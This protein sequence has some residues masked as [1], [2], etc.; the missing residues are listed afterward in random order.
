MEGAARFTQAYNITNCQRCCFRFCCC[1]KD[2]EEFE[3]KLFR[4]H[5]LKVKRAAEP[6]LILWK[7]LGISKWQRRCRIFFS[8]I[9]AIILLFATTLALVYAKYQ[10]NKLSENTV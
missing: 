3:A 4:G 8:T 10:E 9:I 6:S 5:F 7:N 2:R 1:T